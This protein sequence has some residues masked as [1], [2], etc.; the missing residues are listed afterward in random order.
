MHAGAHAGVAA[1]LLNALRQDNAGL[2]RELQGVAA[3]RAINR[4]DISLLRLVVARRGAMPAALAQQLDAVLA[5]PRALCRA[6]N[7]R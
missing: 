2:Q 6:T 5:L 4:L 7:T 3:L 1:L